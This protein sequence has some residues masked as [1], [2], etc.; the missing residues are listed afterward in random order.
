MGLINKTALALMKP[1]AVLIPVSANPVDFDALYHAACRAR[2]SLNCFSNAFKQ[3]QIFG[4][5]SL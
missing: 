2:F 3:R 5:K 1:G 4:A